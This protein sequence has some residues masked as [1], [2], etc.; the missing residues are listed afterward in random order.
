MFCSVAGSCVGFVYLDSITVQWYDL[1]L[2]CCTLEIV[3]NP[4]RLNMWRPGNFAISDFVS[5][6][7][8]EGY[9]GST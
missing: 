8:L 3:Q 6:D 2:Y 5:L 7:T 9:D 1:A 4:Y